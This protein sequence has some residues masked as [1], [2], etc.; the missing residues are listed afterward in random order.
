MPAQIKFSITPSSKRLVLTVGSFAGTG[1]LDIRLTAHVTKLCCCWLL[2]YSIEGTTLT[3]HRHLNVEAAEVIVG[4]TG[5][6]CNLCIIAIFRMIRV[7]IIN[8]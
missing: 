7:T 3:T 5:L 6:G 8:L 1:L 2:R 4:S